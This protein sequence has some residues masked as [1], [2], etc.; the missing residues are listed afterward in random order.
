MFSALLLSF[1][2]LSDRRVL[3][4]LGQTVLLTLFCFIIVGVA[5]WFVLDYGMVRIGYADSKISAL[6]TAV[7]MILTGW[8]LFRVVAIAILWVFS[9]DIVDAVEDRHYPSR[10]QSGTRPNITKSAHMALRSVLRAVGY[11]LLALPL[12]AVLLFTGI[13]PA[14]AF[15]FVNAVLLSR[16][17]RDMLI[18]RHGTAAVNIS[19][20]QGLLLGLLGTAAMLIPFVNFVVPVI[21]T[22]MAVHLAHGKPNGKPG[23]KV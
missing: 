10:A 19:R 22:A 20:F 18:A 13:G 15:L 21:A 5:A 1:Q 8:L 2:S 6:I 4:I 23:G 7:F 3:W 17:L 11:N 14:I 16:D 12:Y 9:D